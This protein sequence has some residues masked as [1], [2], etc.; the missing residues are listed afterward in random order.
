MTGRLMILTTTF[1]VAAALVSTI[2]MQPLPLYIWN[3]SASVPIGSMA[4]DRRSA[5]ISPSCSPFSRLS[6]LRRFS[7]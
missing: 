1:A 5:S 2:A 4:Y 7:T 6:R 3:A